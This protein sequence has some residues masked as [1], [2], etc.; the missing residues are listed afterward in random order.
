MFDLILIEAFASLICS[1]F[2]LGFMKKRLRRKNENSVFFS[3]IEYFDML[4]E[5]HS[6]LE[7]KHDLFSTISPVNAI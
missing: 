4:G 3:D 2:G 1:V 7:F 5:V 6:T